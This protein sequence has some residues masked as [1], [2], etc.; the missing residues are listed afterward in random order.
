LIPR[1][2]EQTGGANG[3]GS[4]TSIYTVLLHEENDPIGELAKSTLD[5]HIVLSRELASRG[6]YPA[7]DPLSSVSRVAHRVSSPEHNRARMRFLDLYARW[8]EAAELIA[9]GS[10]N[11]GTDRRMDEAVAAHEKLETFLRQD[12]NQRVTLEESVRELE[13][14]VS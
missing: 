8:R 7:I 13:E 9:L 3:S 1:L 2:V 6:H 4:I 12:M 5:G 11:P 10:Y 14:A